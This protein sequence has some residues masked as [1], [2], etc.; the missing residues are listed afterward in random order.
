MDYSESYNKDYKDETMKTLYG[1]L[2]VAA[3]VRHPE[4]SFSE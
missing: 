1:R 2:S 4:Y 3:P